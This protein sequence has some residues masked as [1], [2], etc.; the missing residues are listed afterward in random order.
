M[1]TKSVQQFDLPAL[2]NSFINGVTIHMLID[3]RINTLVDIF[4]YASVNVFVSAFAS[5]YIS[6]NV[7]TC[8]VCM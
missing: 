6:A 5:A 8:I 2:I 4:D 1:V 3:T 7:S